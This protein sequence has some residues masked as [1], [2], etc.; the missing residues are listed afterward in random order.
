[1]EEMAM[2]MEFAIMKGDMLIIKGLGPFL[3]LLI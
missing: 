1:V 2:F 3:I